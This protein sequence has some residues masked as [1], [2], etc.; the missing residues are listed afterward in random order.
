MMR[1]RYLRPACFCA[2]T[3]STKLSHSGYCRFKYPAAAVLLCGMIAMLGTSD[4]ISELEI[5]GRMNESSASEPSLAQA[6]TAP[7]VNASVSG[8]SHGRLSDAAPLVMS[9]TNNGSSAGRIE[10]TLRD[11]LVRASVPVDVREQIEHLFAPRLDLAAPA[12]KGDT[13]HVL[14]GRDA[15]DARR[16]RLTAVEIRSGGE[17]YQA[18]WFIAPGRT[19]GHY[20]SFDGGRLAAKPFSMPLD[21]V[22][23]S[24]PFGYRTHPVKGKHLMHTGVDF[25][26]PKG[27][28]VVAAA[29]GTVRF[30]GFKPGYGK[31]VVL[32]HPRGFT[33]HYAHLSAFARDLRIGKPVTEGQPLGAVGSTGTATGHHLHFEVREYDQ[34]IDPLTLTRRTDTAQLTTSQRIAFDSMTGALREQLAALPLDT[35][36]NRMASN[37]ESTPNPAER[38]KSSLT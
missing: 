13:Y 5:V 22:R 28:P 30:I 4:G 9:E 26:A 7:A 2:Q 3:T 14:Y 37:A 11:T 31:I 24:S 12:R 15:T 33:T 20:Y 23:L 36:A 18:V 1:F 38:Q 25:A 21:Y 17:F 34:P 8:T 6:A 16:K 29:S 10:G 35:P 19:D 32:R 27:T